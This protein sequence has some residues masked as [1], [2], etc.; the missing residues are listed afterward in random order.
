MA[1]SLD[2]RDVSV[3]IPDDSDDRRRESSS[4]VGQHQHRLSAYNPAIAPITAAN[5]T[6]NSR[7]H[8][9]S[10]HNEAK[11]DSPDQAATDDTPVAHNSP[12]LRE[13]AAGTTIAYS[14]PPPLLSTLSP[15]R[16]L[17]KL[18]HPLEIASHYSPSKD[19][20]DINKD[21]T[22]Y[23][24]SKS[25]PT[26][27]VYPGATYAASSPV[28]RARLQEHKIGA[29]EQRLSRESGCVRGLFVYLSVLFV[30]TV[31]AFVAGVYYLNHRDAS[32]LTAGA[33]QTGM[34]ADGAVTTPK[35]AA[36]AVDLPELSPPIAA[37]VGNM[38]VTYQQALGR[39]PTAG[40]GLV[41]N[42]TAHTLSVAYDPAT[43]T[44]TGANV[45]TV[46]AGGV[47]GA[48][49]AAGSVGAAQLA[50]G[51]VGASALA[52]GSVGVPALGADVLALVAALNASAMQAWNA[53]PVAGAGVIVN[54]GTVSINYDPTTL[55]ITP[56]NN[57]LTIAPH[58]LTT[59]Q[60]TPAS[61]TLA[62][63]SPAFLASLPTAGAG[64]ALI[65]NSLAVVADP[66]TLTL[67]G[68]VLA[69]VNGS[70]TAAHL[71]DGAVGFAALSPVL[72]A[73]LVAIN[74]TAASA[75]Y[76]T[77]ALL[78]SQSFLQQQLLAA[79]NVSESDLLASVANQ[80]TALFDALLAVNASTY[81]ALS[82][83]NYTAF[84]FLLSVNNNTQYF[85]SLI[86]STTATLLAAI[87]QPGL[88]LTAT[89]ATYAIKADPAVF[90]LASSALTLRAQAITAG[91]LADGGVTSGK[92]G[93]GAVGS[94]QLAEGVVSM[95]KLSGGLQSALA[96]LNVDSS[97]S[98]SLL[99]LGSPNSSS[100]FVVTHP[101]G[102]TL[103]F[104]AT[105]NQ[106]VCLVSAGVSSQLSVG[107]SGVSVV[108]AEHF[109][110]SAYQSGIALHAQGE[111][112]SMAASDIALVA[113][114][115][116]IN[117]SSSG[118]T[119]ASQQSATITAA[120]VTLNAS[121]SITINTPALTFTGSVSYTPATLIVSSPTYAIDF[122]A[123]PANILRLTGTVA[124]ANVSFTGC[125]DATAGTTAT[126]Y[127]QLTA[128]GT[129]R[130]LAGTCGNTYYD[131]LLLAA[132]RVTVSCSGVVGG[133]P[134]Y[135]CARG[136]QA[137]GG[138]AVPSST[139]T[140]LNNVVNG[141][142]LST[143][144][145][146]SILLSFTPATSVA[147]LSF[148]IS[149]PLLA[150]PTSLGAVLLTP[151][152]SGTVNSQYASSKQSPL[153]VCTRQQLVSQQLTVT[154]VNVGDS[155]FV[156]QSQYVQFGYQI[157]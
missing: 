56:S 152:Q 42:Y 74:D 142:A 92:L 129:L 86:T 133:V 84:Q 91:L 157:L 35:L 66:T 23:S 145:V 34:L 43:L 103:L 120:I 98:T 25:F 131:I 1:F 112:I 26:G 3:H 106:S 67:S 58:S 20:K 94:V 123:L 136:E 52:A 139:V 6:D 15:H 138:L 76:N 156:N 134:A 63:L 29:I 130:I 95:D 93:V 40:V 85:T 62:S 150:A 72:E 30:I 65:N 55:A 69:V 115:S 155:L 149:N 96:L 49:L 68:G 19:I 36:G 14:A 119:L 51:S 110:V 118:I 22:A 147:T 135:M 117:V 128:G 48:M 77:Q 87:P 53:R 121:T 17:P 10:Q 21:H 89:N 143:T 81:T 153:W 127:N 88:G 141:I 82:S 122:S 80:S 105:F 32:P 7:D 28:A 47:K 144:P 59:A 75:L 44:I 148:V 64:L 151:Q 61:I 2:T 5:S 12:T 60:I 111:L 100:P 78:L 13:G 46:A 109:S 41:Q 18:P 90:S 11:Y 70:I 99:S 45:L 97:S 9:L 8:S 124:N 116:A 101:A 79:L 57:T 126:V 125:S 154:V 107:D 146:G 33:V 4:V 71:A 31:V 137:E 113:S 73:S 108:S 37:L 27:A 38:N 132:Q 54:G 24:P 39:L 50:A 104:Q 102:G 16:P 83:V 114:S 140:I